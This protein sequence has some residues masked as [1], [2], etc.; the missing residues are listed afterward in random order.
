MSYAQDLD[1]LDEIA[2]KI[3]SHVIIQDAIKDEYA[4]QCNVASVYS[5]D[6][7]R[8]LKQKNSL[9]VLRK[10]QIHNAEEIEKLENAKKTIPVRIAKKLGDDV[11][12]YLGRKRYEKDRRERHKR[13]ARIIGS[14]SVVT[15][16][17]ACSIYG[18][19]SNS[20][21]KMNAMSILRS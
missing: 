17:L 3:A 19:Q 13:Y 16:I 9:D 15:L 6:P 10:K 14:A 21:K 11:M 8:Y 5:V 2:N 18:Y 1:E 20:R 12:N 7:F 4:A